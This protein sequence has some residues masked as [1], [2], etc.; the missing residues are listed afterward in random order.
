MRCRWRQRW[1][2]GALASHGVDPS[3]DWRRSARGDGP[4]ALSNGAAYDDCAGGGRSPSGIA[5]GGN[6]VI[7][8]LQCWLALSLSGCAAVWGF[9]DLTLGESDGGADASAD[10]AR[11]HDAS[12]PSDGSPSND[13]SPPTDASSPT[14]GASS[15][16]V[17]CLSSNGSCTC[18]THTAQPNGAACSPEVLGVDGANVICCADP[19]FP[20]NGSCTCQ[21]IG[22]TQ[23]SGNC[24]CGPLNGTP[25][26]SCAPSTYTCCIQQSASECVCANQACQTGF[27]ENG[28]ACAIHELKCA[29]AQRQVSAC[30]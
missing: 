21:W 7:R 6:M 19:T 8:T 3:L 15:S 4:R 1:K 12:N 18:A 27:T 22:C 13:A 24:I 9:D 17:E 10:D 11:A 28:N 25:G 23:S 20:A 5:R 26:G 16:E 29:G 30:N 14:D 2:H